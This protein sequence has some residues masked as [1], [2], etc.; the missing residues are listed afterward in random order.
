M[1]SW[2]SA[3]P[4][5]FPEAYFIRTD[6]ESGRRVHIGKPVESIRKDC[7]PQRRIGSIQRMVG[8]EHGSST[9]IYLHSM[10]DSEK[11]AIDRNVNENM[12]T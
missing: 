3:T 1:S 8:H 9:E 4:S 12:Q 10:G 5:G 11:M 2:E 7:R 6:K